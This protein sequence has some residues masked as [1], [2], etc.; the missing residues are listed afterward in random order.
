MAKPVNCICEN[1]ACSFTC[2]FFAETIAPC[3]G[4]VH[5]NLYNDKEPFIKC[6]MTNLNEFECDYFK[7][8]K[9]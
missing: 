2:E 7:E 3:L 9:N 1:C 4:V 5:V 8:R 6:L